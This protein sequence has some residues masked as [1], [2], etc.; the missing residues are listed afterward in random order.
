MAEI[1]A[2]SYRAVGRT[3]GVTDNTIRKW[4]RQYRRE[5]LRRCVVVGRMRGPVTV[6]VH[7]RPPQARPT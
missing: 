1:N 7:R 2:T 5:R 4:L 3:Y 6:V